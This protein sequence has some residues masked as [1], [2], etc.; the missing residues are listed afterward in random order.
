[1]RQ[2]RARKGGK[3]RARKLSPARRRGIASQAAKA[4]WQQRLP[5]TV[6]TT[7]DAPEIIQRLCARRD[8]DGHA[9]D[10]AV[11]KMI[12][13]NGSIDPLT[14]LL[15]RSGSIG[16]LF[17]TKT[18]QGI[19]TA[20]KRELTHLRSVNLVDTSPDVDQLESLRYRVY[21]A[22]IDE[23]A[24]ARQG[25]QFG[26]VRPAM[27]DQDQLEIQAS[28][29]SPVPVRLQ[30]FSVPHLEQEMPVLLGERVIYSGLNYARDFS[31][32]ARELLE[33]HCD[34]A[35]LMRLRFLSS[36]WTR[37]PRPEAFPVVTKYLIPELYRYLL[38]F[39]RARAHA[40]LEHLGPPGRAAF[41]RQLMN[42]I[43]AVLRFE[44]PDLCAKLTW[45]Q[46]LAAVRRSRE[47]TSEAGSYS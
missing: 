22:L 3:A 17:R 33:A 36:G 23:P 18:Y 41:P 20:I 7:R 5:T 21:Q 16:R 2:A 8:R 32:A 13:M 26:V 46:V 12:A 45:G 29:P 27:S 6:H 4:R 43:A 15:L 24:L 14:M 47:R 31:D 30:I 37:R 19:L 42:D 11:I 40:R 9:P 38:P 1:M 28:I 34:R 25:R 44:R 39:Y 10:Y 35:R